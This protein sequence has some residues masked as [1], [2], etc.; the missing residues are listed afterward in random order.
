MLVNV[1]IFLVVLVLLV[2]FVWL[3]T[4]ANRA[5]NAGLRWVGMILSGLVALVLAAVAILAVVGYYRL[6]VPLYHYQTSE[7]KVKGTAEQIAL[8]GRRAALCADCHSTNQKDLDGSAFNFF[9]GS[10]MGVLYAPNLTPSGRLKDWT[11][12]QVLRAIREGVDAEG[13]TLIIMPSEGMH[14]M[15][16]NDAQALVAFL[17]SLPAIERQTP[18]RALSFL[19]IVLTGANQFPLEAQPPITG[20]VLAPPEG[21]VDYGKYI[22]VAFGC[23]D[24]HGKDLRGNEEEEG[25]PNLVGV[26]SGWSEDQFLHFFDTGIDP[27]GAQISDEMPWKAYKIALSDGE[28]H[29]LYEYLHDLLPIASTN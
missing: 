19:G 7:L 23:S 17:R 29:D 6:N 10:P 13:K 27:N 21:T 3:A 28:K 25:G 16:D 8:G 20:V 22:T 12:A 15:S 5:R 26:V 2:F 4:R 14:A 18:E 1:V 11:D 9:E 24:C